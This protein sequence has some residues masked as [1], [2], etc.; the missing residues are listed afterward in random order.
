MRRPAALVA[1]A[2]AL[3]GC[4]GA[5]EPAAPD[6]FS[7]VEPTAVLPP[8]ERDAAAPRWVRLARLRADGDATRTLEIPGKSIQWRIRWRCRG[9]GAITMRLDPPA[10][11]ADP[12]VDGRC[13][14][15]GEAP[16]VR[17]GRMRLAVR[18]SGAWSAV[19]EHQVATPLREPPLPEMRAPGAARL[20]RGE[21]R[22]IERRGEGAVAL[23][24]LPGGR[25]ALR[26][27]HF[28]TTPST[29]LEIWVGRGRRPATSR[30][31]VRARHVSIGELK[32]TAGSQNYLLPRRLRAS[33]VRFVVLWCEPLYMAY[34]AA[35]LRAR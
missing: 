10:A 23:H 11:D 12:L 29:D 21:F 28:R 8:E 17:G 20:A 3:A 16:A 24:R 15:R 9:A 35:G 6:P 31:A 19:V 27:E 22:P 13:P 5:R 30:A 7:K 4:G 18:A 34:A 2:V 32:S 33:D 26:F 25:L 1:A 14:G